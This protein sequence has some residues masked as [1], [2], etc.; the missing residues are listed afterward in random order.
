MTRE[1]QDKFA[2]SSQQKAAVAM[3]EG[4]FK[5]EIA[6]VTIKSRKGETVIDTDE[7]PKP[8]TTFEGLQKLRPAFKTVSFSKIF[9]HLKI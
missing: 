7:F 8:S 6:P 9:L 4:Y 1:D 3:K 2:A 5:N